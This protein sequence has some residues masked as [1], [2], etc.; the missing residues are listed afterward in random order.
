[1]RTILIPSWL[2]LEVG[3]HR[4]YVHLGFKPFRR[5]N[6]FDKLLS[7]KIWKGSPVEHH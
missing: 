3:V 2:S 4:L 1:M 7:F 6:E 5:T